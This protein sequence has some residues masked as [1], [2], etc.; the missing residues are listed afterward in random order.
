M[1]KI[2]IDGMSSNM[3]GVEK[4][5]C[6]IYEALKDEWQV[7]FITVDESIP[8]QEEFL[9]N[10]SQIHKITPRY[11]S[12]SK[13]KND[14]KEV[15]KN[16]QYDVFWFN[17]T[18]LSSID[19]IKE[20]KNSGIKNVICHSHQS[21]NMGTLFTLLM[22]NMNKRN[23]GKYIDYRVACSKE[24][25]EWFFGS[26][27]EDVVIFPNAV[28]IGKYEPNETLRT[29]KRKELGIEGKFVI[30]NVARFA[31]EKN[32]KF[33]IDIFAELCK[34]EDAVLVSC[35]EGPLWEETK[36]Y[37]KEKKI[38]DKILFLGMRKDIPEI[39]QAI[40][41]VVF[42]SLFEG[43]PFSLVEAQA[44]GIPCL[45]SD[46]IGKETKLT[47]LV[48]FFSLD[49]G[50]EAWA[51]EILKYKDYKKVT[52][53]NQLEEKGFSSEIIEKKIKEMVNH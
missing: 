51:D 26:K 21:K 39:L 22:H 48:K 50:A 49:A 11:V 1:K 17:K 28:N 7:E 10:G 23:V 34:K 18:T 2:L 25:A 45:I 16:N 30:G 43:L 53:R 38:D 4:F 46:T 52:K 19:C 5:V 41:V 12:V 3:G 32:H 44:G 9:R 27:T 6:T 31:K 40:D 47:D 42:P 24:A 33:L 13:Y 20:A 8:Y 15:F 35:G 36:N 14:I 29:E 37:A